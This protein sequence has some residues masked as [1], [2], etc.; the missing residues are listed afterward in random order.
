MPKSK[1]HGKW[2]AEDTRFDD[3]VSADQ[4]ILGWIDKSSKLCNLLMLATV[5]SSRG[6]VSKCSPPLFFV[7]F[8][9]FEVLRQCLY[10]MLLPSAGANQHLAALFLYL[11]SFLG[12]SYY[13]GQTIGTR[14]LLLKFT[15]VQYVR[16]NLSFCTCTYTFHDSFFFDITAFWGKCC[17]FYSLVKLFGC[18]K[19]L[20]NPTL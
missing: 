13:Y 4:T 3:S 1:Y 2:A 8:L 18:L 15:Q 5:R 10:L 16:T 11:R 12:P 14:V 7:F 20:V 9:Y 17:T 6:L 19:L